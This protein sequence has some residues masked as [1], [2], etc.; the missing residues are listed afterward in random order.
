MTRRR[1]ANTAPRLI[2]GFGGAALSGALIDE[3]RTRTPDTCI[4]LTPF[5][6][7]ARDLAALAESAGLKDIQV[8]T[9]AGYAQENAKHSGVAAASKVQ[10]WLVLHRILFDHVN[11]AGAPFW[12]KSER[13]FEALFQLVDELR[14]N[15]VK[16]AEIEALRDSLPAAGFLA[17]VLASC[18]KHLKEKGIA[19][20]PGLVRKA[21][22]QARDNP[23]AP[24]S[25][26]ILDSLHDARPDE[27]EMALALAAGP[28]SILITY[29]PTAPAPD[30]RPVIRDVA[31]ELG[32]RLGSCETEAAPVLP[33][34]AAGR[35]IASGRPDELGESAHLLEYNDLASQYRGLAEVSRGLVLDEGMP[36][37]E[38]AFLVPDD[39][40]ERGLMHYEL[41]R[42]GLIREEGPGL[43]PGVVPLEREVRLVLSLLSSPGRTDLIHRALSAG[44]AASENELTSKLATLEESA[45]SLG[46][47]QFIVQA[48]SLLLTDLNQHEK[49]ALE[50]YR[51]A[52]SDFEYLSGSG[53]I[54]E[55]LPV[56]ALSLSGYVREIVREETDLPDSFL[57]PQKP[58]A[59]RYGAVIVSSLVSVKPTPIEVPPGI[60]ELCR[61]LEHRL[62]CR[63]SLPSRQ[64]RN[65]RRNWEIGAAVAAGERAFLSLY[66]QRN[67]RK[68]E[69]LG[70]LKNIA[71]SATRVPVVQAAQVK[72]VAPVESARPVSVPQVLSP[73]AIADYIACPHMFY[74]GTVLGLKK[75]ES[76]RLRLGSLLHRVLARFHA[77]G[78]TDFSAEKMRSILEE[79]AG[80]W[81]L[82]AE[83]LNEAR[84]LL[85]AYIA[86]QAPDV[87][88]TVAV[89]KSFGLQ[90]GGVTIRGRIDRIVEVPGG[91]KIIDYKT[92]GKGKE[93]KHRNA[94][95]ER[96]DN[97]QLPLYALGARET[98]LNVKA[99]SYIFLNHEDTYRPYEAVVRFA[100]D[101]KSDSISEMQLLDSLARIETVVREI[102]AGGIEFPKGQNAPCGKDAGWCDFLAMCSLAAS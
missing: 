3:L 87:E 16:S 25:V 35:K 59:R 102:T 82:D 61:T 39:P 12:T 15:F 49:D 80:A 21:T 76:A 94:A 7:R 52:A 46:F 70:L 44:M 88:Q 2:E 5:A 71:E 28:A 32:K 18:E 75:E 51:A 22:E 57:G 27:F 73:T 91:V 31:S 43:T 19:D 69:P 41:L 34:E 4:I 24:A 81:E 83:S 56:F 63:I 101:G 58:P 38:L 64:S 55:D 60:P 40:V 9:Y 72:P 20:L 50:L 6:A 26:L 65:A 86:G 37:G 53:V 89:E 90:F 95:T 13:G 23:D 1:P 100:E 42:S 17:G 84:A 93:K 33:N 8:L 77:P 99:F 98:G 92:R 14:A 68:V 74:L 10:R 47:G 67:G 30:N 62:G 36:A 79:N 97:V 29:D 45:K 78:E 54:G 48:L 96:L 66:R 11:T 85:D